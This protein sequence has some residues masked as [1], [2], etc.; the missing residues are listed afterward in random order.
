MLRDGI[1]IQEVFIMEL[2]QL[3]YFCD[4]AREQ[5]F[6]KTAKKFSVPASNISQSIKRLE[7][8]L[9]VSLFDRSANSISLNNKGRDFYKKISEALAVIEAAKNEVNNAGSIRIGINANRRIVMQTVEKL[10]QSYP[11]VDITAMYSMRQ[12]EDFDLLI[13]CDKSL[14]SIYS[15]EKLLSEKIVLAMRDDDPLVN[16]ENITPNILNGRSFIS[17]DPD[18]DMQKETA[19]IAQKMGIEPRFA[20]QTVDAYYVR[21]CIE[22]GMGLAFVPVFSWKGQFSDRIVFKDVGNYTRDTY[23][24]KKHEKLCSSYCDIFINMLREEIK[25]D[26]EC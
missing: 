12:D 16:C 6:S 20:I 3:K 22:A 19:K 17:M 15:G 24:F 9:C 25:N 2:L 23:V 4:A 26:T 14:L 21:R 18:S 1:I 11:S 8:E 7:K 13:S 5:S 10:Q